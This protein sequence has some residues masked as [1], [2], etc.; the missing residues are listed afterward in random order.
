MNPISLGAT[1]PD[2]KNLE[3][4]SFKKIVQIQITA[5]QKVCPECPTGTEITKE[6]PSLC[7]YFMTNTL[8]ISREGYVWKG[9]TPLVLG[10]WSTRPYTP[11]NE[12]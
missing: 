1:S 6:S 4:F 9:F 3:L 2:I 10:P 8:I 12:H 11:Q 5:A 7:F